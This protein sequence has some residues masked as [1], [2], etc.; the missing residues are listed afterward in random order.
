MEK[1]L[2]SAQVNIL[3]RF[4]SILH[5]CLSHFII[6]NAAISVAIV[7]YQP[8]GTLY[9][10]FC[11][12]IWFGVVNW[13]ISEM[14]ILL[15]QKSFECICSEL[16]STIST[17]LFRYAIIYK[18]V[19]YYIYQILV[20]GLA[21]LKVIYCY[22]AALPI[23]IYQVR[24]QVCEEIICFKWNHSKNCTH[25]DDRETQE[26]PW[27]KFF[28]CGVLLKK[29]KGTVNHKIF[30]NFRVFW[31]LWYIKILCQE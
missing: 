19:S 29:N 15:F 6:I 12:P 31:Q 7:R 16:W 26:N 13:R 4:A 25:W 17:K 22:P 3:H 28:S 20:S 2:S 23:S 27:L 9:C 1:N 14:Y 18:K 24:V 8:F 11:S 21:R 10:Y 5:D 30:K